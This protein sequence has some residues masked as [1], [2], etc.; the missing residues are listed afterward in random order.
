MRAHPNMMTGAQD[1]T[2]VRSDIKAVIDALRTLVWTT[3]PD[4]YVDFHNRCWSEYTGLRVDEAVGWGW[5]AI[6][7][8]EDRPWLLEHWQ[9]IRASGEP[10][11]DEGRLRR[12][13]GEYRW[14]LVRNTP[15]RDAT[16]RIVKW[17]GRKVSYIFLSPGQ[18]DITRAR[19][20]SRFPGFV[21]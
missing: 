5:Q 19:G 15:L 9:A 16:G 4:G 8:P 7:P 21:L 12:F 1:H 18:D 11:E 10:S 20:L 17:Y 6:V 2:A 13:D 14:F 3:R